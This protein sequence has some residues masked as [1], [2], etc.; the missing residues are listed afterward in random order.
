MKIIRWLSK[1]KYSFILY[2]HK[3]QH[4]ILS[5]FVIGLA[6]YFFLYELS[7]SVSS[8]L[9]VE[10]LPLVVVV[11]TILII[12]GLVKYIRRKMKEKN[13]FLFY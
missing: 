8:L 1:A 9:V 11:F 13:H 12:R 2:Y 4:Y 5:L 6:D 3:I 10:A 7:L